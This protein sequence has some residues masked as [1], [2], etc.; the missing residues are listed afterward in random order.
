MAA[1]ALTFQLYS[2]QLQAHELLVVCR[3]LQIPCTTAGAAQQDR[4]AESSNGAGPAATADPLS[5]SSHAPLLA[6]LQQQAR[7]AAVM[8]GVP[9]EPE[10]TPGGPQGLK[11]TENVQAAFARLRQLSEAAAEPARELEVTLL[12]SLVCSVTY[13]VHV[14]I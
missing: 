6:Q 8:G 9:V 2:L 13:S 7:E 10:P 14:K 5:Q 3:D 11:G 12:G 4:L 1:A